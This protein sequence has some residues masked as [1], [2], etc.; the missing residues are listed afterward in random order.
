MKKSWVEINNVPSTV[1]EGSL[2]NG[3]EEVIPFFARG[4]NET[5]ELATSSSLERILNGKKKSAKSI[6]EIIFH[7]LK[8]GFN[9]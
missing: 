1:L 9:E 7:N 8:R 3:E 5:D 6:S 4:E 2:G